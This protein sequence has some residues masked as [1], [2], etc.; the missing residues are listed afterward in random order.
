M[1]ENE[2]RRF[3]EANPCSDGQA[4]GLDAEGCFRDYDAFRSTCEIEAF[5][6]LRPVIEQTP[7]QIASEAGRP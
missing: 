1:D 7:I 2:I 6:E 4:G 5:A 3:W